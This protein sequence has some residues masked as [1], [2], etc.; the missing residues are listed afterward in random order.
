MRWI[1]SLFVHLWL[2]LTWCPHKDDSLSSNGK[3]KLG[4]PLQT[5]TSCACLF[6]VFKFRGKK[7]KR[8]KK[9]AARLT[10]RVRFSI[11]ACGT[12][13]HCV[14]SVWFG[15]WIEGNGYSAFGAHHPYEKK[16]ERES[17][18]QRAPRERMNFLLHHIL[19][20][21]PILVGMLLSEDINPFLSVK[22]DIRYFC[23]SVLLFSPIPH[24]FLWIFTY[25]L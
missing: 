19:K 5:E 9:A 17:E 8:R 4:S 20:I 21:N 25:M 15:W 18:F 14:F 13:T 24:V 2:L 11:S 6:T 16:K 22:S 12:E 10:P 3:N 1:K 7:K 23:C